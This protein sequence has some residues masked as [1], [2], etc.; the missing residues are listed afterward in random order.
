MK[1]SKPTTQEIKVYIDSATHKKFKKKT[2]ASEMSMSQ[3]MR[4]QIMKYTKD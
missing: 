3:W 4:H 2:L 1:A